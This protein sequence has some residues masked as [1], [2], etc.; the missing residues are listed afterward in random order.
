MTALIAVAAIE[1]A[2]RMTPVMLLIVKES[3]SKGF[4]LGSILQFVRSSVEYKHQHQ[5]AVPH[6]AP[7][8]IDCYCCGVHL[9]GKIAFFLLD[10]SA[11][12]LPRFETETETESR[13]GPS[14]PI[15]AR[16]ARN[17][18]TPSTHLAF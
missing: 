9:G 8:A 12:F 4:A 13:M 17:Q 2:L 1:I 14:R 10:E 11:M 16:S 3:P 6:L 18:S 7:Q 15:L 5:H